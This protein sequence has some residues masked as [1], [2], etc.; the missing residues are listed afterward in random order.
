MPGQSQVNPSQPQVNPKSTP[1]QAKSTP[2]QPKSTP[3]PPKSTRRQPQVSPK[4][5]QA[6]PETAL[7][8]GFPMVFTPGCCGLPNFPR[9]L[10]MS[11]ATKSALWRCRKHANMDGQRRRTDSAL[12]SYTYIYTCRYIYTY[13]SGNPGQPQVN[14]TQPQGDPKSTPSQ[15]QVDPTAPA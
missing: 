7:A 5:T 8:I 15:P 9:G 1:S 6:F 14:S 13:P 10:Q 3:C 12:S 4:S 2:N 11:W